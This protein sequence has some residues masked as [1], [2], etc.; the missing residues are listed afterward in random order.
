MSCRRGVVGR[1]NPASGIREEADRQESFLVRCDSFHRHDFEG[2]R[3]WRLPEPATG[4]QQQDDQ[5]P[6][7]RFLPSNS[8][9]CIGLERGSDC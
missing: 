7:H 5:R 3:R 4:T 9:R 1:P 6:S 2:K 8:R